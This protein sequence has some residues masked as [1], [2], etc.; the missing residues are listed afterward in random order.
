MLPAQ[1]PNAL[2]LK[3]ER[4]QKGFLDTYKVKNRRYWIY[5]AA[6]KLWSRGMPWQTA[7]D[8][9]TEAFEGATHEA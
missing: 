2:R 6:A 8:I 5:T 4:V 3:T 7:L 9:V 1:E